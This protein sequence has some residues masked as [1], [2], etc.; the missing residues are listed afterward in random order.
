[1]R[2]QTGFDYER[3][4][5]ASTGVAW[6]AAGLALFV[7]LTPLLMPLIFPQSMQH[8]SPVAAPAMSGD[9]PRLELTPR[10]NLQ[11]FRQSEKQ[12]T[13]TY[14]WSDREHG[15]VR[16]PVAQA[17]KILLNKGLPGWPSR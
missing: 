9:A 8:H 4:D 17:M 13:E 10:E 6:I 15:L 14:G 7:L 1:M 16:I 5:I 2:E 3:T 12:L 11:R